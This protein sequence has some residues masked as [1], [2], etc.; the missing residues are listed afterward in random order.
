MILVFADQTNRTFFLHGGPAQG[1][2]ENLPDEL[3]LREQR[4]PPAADWEEAGRRAATILGL[5]VSPLASAASVAKLAADAKQV[6][7]DHAPRARRS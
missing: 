1:T 5:A 4:L 6:A 7:A 3:E 2:I